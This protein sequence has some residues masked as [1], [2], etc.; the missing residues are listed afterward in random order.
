MVVYFLVTNSGGG[1]GDN[2]NA[3]RGIDLDSLHIVNTVPID[4]GDMPQV[5]KDNMVRPGADWQPGANAARNAA[6]VRY[7]RR[8]NRGR[9]PL[10]F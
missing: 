4:T 10:K 8:L 5:F 9:A 3:K 7:A 2:N 1:G 6:A